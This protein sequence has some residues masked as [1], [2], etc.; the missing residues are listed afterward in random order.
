[1]LIIAMHGAYTYPGMPHTS[2]THDTRACARTV[3]Y[4][5]CSMIDRRRPTTTRVRVYVDMMNINQLQA[6]VPGQA[7]SWQGWADWAPMPIYASVRI[8]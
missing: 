7:V 4:V 6:Y 5:R 8:G 1:M 2:V 3:T